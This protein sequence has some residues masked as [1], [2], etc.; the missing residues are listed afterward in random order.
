PPPRRTEPGRAGGRGNADAGGFPGSNTAGAPPVGAPTAVAGGGG[1]GRGG[2]AA[3]PSGPNQCHDITVYPDIGLA[4]GACGGYG[5][6]LDIRETAHPI[7][8]DAAA[9]INM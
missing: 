1:G 8:I 3:A 6:L 5:L 9:D 7:R 2:A 4:G